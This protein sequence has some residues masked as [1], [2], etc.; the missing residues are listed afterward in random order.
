MKRLDLF[1]GALALIAVS[2][3]AAPVAGAQEN[4]NRDM[5]GNIVRGPYETNSFGDN[6]FIGAGGGINVFLGDGTEIAIAPN[7]DANIGKWF[8]PSVGMRICY[9]GFKSEFLAEA[10]SVLGRVKD[11]GKGM[12]EQT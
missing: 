1:F 10:P 5:D 7:I 4:G 9:Q 6:W 12:Y 3:T 11:V 2:M 8:T